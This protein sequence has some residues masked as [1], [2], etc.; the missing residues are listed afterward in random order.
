MSLFYVTMCLNQLSRVTLQSL[1][2]WMVMGTPPGR[3]W[4]ADHLH[5]QD[6]GP[7]WTQLDRAG[8]GPKATAERDWTKRDRSG[9]SPMTSRGPR[10][11]EPKKSCLCNCRGPSRGRTQLWTAVWRAACQRRPPDTGL[12]CGWAK[13]QPQTGGPTK[14]RAVV[15]HLW[16]EEAG[17][18]ARPPGPP[19]RVA[20]TPTMTGPYGGVA[21]TWFIS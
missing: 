21:V 5:S 9:C 11:S 15:L 12:S 7:A 17:A 20:A 16:R 2:P 14:P 13:T 3:S 18:D 19:E 1:C 10:Q 4:H 8:L 6:L